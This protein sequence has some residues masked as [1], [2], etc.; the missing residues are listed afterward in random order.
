MNTQQQNEELFDD[1][2]AGKMDKDS[3]LVFETQLAQDSA[4]NAAF[5]LHKQ[6]VAQ[7]EIASMKKKLTIIHDEL[8]ARQY[9]SENKKTITFPSF[10]WTKSIAAAI[11]IGII[12]FGVYKYTS[13]NKEA[14]LYATYYTQDVGLPSFMSE[15]NH[16]TFDDAMVD[17]KSGEYAI[18]INKLKAITE[19]NAS[20][21]TINYYL[22]MAYMGQEEY[23]NAIPLLSKLETEQ[24]PFHQKASWYKGLAALKTGQKELAIITFKE[25]AQNPSNHYA[26]QA[27]EILSTLT[28]KH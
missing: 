8:A 6:V 21:D 4:L 24:N 13:S 1:Y 3:A 23:D 15:S 25:I 2:L 14:K 22:A 16:Y 20:N 9:Q 19:H 27:E 7:I 18:A 12:G 28:D 11:A 10:K 26:Q 5:L 17:Y